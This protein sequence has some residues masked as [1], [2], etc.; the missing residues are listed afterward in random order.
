MI[1]YNAKTLS[2]AYHIQ[3]PAVRTRFDFMFELEIFITLIQF[4]LVQSKTRING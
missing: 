2:G 4:S 1:R 3:N